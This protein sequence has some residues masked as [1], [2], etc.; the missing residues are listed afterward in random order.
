[1]MRKALEQARTTAVLFGASLLS[2]P[3]L[4]GAFTPPEGCE[5]YL[6]VQMKG[7]VVEHSYK[8]S[9]A[10]G[11]YWTATFDQF[12]FFSLKHLDENGYILGYEDIRAG[13]SMEVLNI[14]KAHFDW[15]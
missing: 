14:F 9:S 6:T 13:L 8:C 5:A 10:P 4:A 7:C 11:D 3:A 15:R 2:A 12:G 1:M